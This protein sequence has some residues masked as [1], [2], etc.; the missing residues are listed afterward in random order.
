MDRIL[1]KQLF[2]FALL[3]LP[4]IAHAAEPASAAATNESGSLNV[5]LISLVTLIF[6]LL[7]VVGILGNVLR[8]LGFVYLDKVKTERKN[9][10]AVK[11][12]LVL[13]GLGGISWSANAQAAAE[14]AQAATPAL[15]TS[16]SGIPANEFYLLLGAIGLELIV[17]TALILSI[18]TVVR[19]LSKKPELKPIAEAIVRRSF[20][21]RFHNVVAIE[22]EEEIMLDHDY[23]GIKELDNSLPAWW[24]YG[25]YL[26]ILVAFIYMYYY[27]FGGGGPSSLQEYTAEVEKGEVD[28]A[29]Y[30]AKSDNNVDETTVKLLDASGIAAGEVTFQNMCAACHAKDGGGGV[31]PN[32]TDDYWLHGGSLSDVFKSIK[33]GWPDKGMKSWKDDFSP[34]QIAEL[35]SYIKSIKGSNPAAPKD[36]QGELYTESEVKADSAQIAMVK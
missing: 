24:K 28:K 15:P 30:L 4:V 19:L 7:I 9:S 13:L 14:T 8:Q 25:F 3:L 31:G 27:H 23:D 17:I 10:V 12:L 29:A 33:Y 36:K 32:L 5:V 1:N 34:K 18:R 20:W 26:T 6:V 35:T 2:L 16:Y 22:K 21:D 11:S